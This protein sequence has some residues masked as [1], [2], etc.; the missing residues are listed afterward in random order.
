MATTDMLTGL[1]NRRH[2]ESMV[3]QEMARAD[4]HEQ[5]LSLL[6]FD[7]DHFKEFND[8]YS[9]YDGDRV[10]RILSKILHD[11]VKGTVS[12]RGFVGHIGG[13]DFIVLSTPDKMETLARGICD[14]FD[15]M[16][17]TRPY[18]IAMPVPRAL[19]HIAGALG[20][21]F[22][23]PLG[24]HFLALGAEGLLTVH[25]VA[26]Q[27]FAYLTMVEGL[28]L[29]AQTFNKDVKQLSCCAG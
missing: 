29:C 1:W 4:R 6:I 2:F 7:L 12:E 5:A 24:H 22:D 28:K 25:D 14:A 10:I 18:R 23:V 17:S 3:R 9:Y 8:R 26:D 16:T 21:Q 13:D 11:V 20:R 27:L 19:D 15:A